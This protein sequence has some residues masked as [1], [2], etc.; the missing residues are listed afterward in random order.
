MNV[1]KQTLN[2]EDSVVNSHITLP[3]LIT[4]V[5]ILAVPLFV[6]FITFQFL[7]PGHGGFCYCRS[8]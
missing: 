1:R 7:R 3:N 2:Q 5:R 6:I 4:M 8:E